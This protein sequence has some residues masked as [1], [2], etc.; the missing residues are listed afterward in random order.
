[1][2][3]Q[4]SAT[5]SSISALLDDARRE[6]LQSFQGL[7]DEQMTAPLPDGWSVKD[8]LAHVAMWDE[9]ELPDMRRAAR[10]DQPAFESFD[11]PFI[12]QWNHIQLV[13][14]SR[15]LA[16]QVLTELTESRQAIMD[17]LSSLPDELL[18]T[19]Y[20]PMACMHSIRHDQRH[21]EQIRGWRQQEESA[22]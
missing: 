12:D 19:G 13:L 8:I 11:Y 2:A 1:M 15:F 18:A 3:T 4:S 14:R 6:L 10:G 17:F 21:A 22:P 9:M 7:T 20:I 16:K 5:R